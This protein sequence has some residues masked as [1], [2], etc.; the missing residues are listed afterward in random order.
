MRYEKIVFDILKNEKK[1]S[2]WRVQRDYAINVNA[3]YN[4]EIITKAM[5]KAME[6]KAKI[7]K[8][9]EKYNLDNELEIIDLD[10]IEKKIN[11]YERIND[12]KAN[13]YKQLREEILK[14]LYE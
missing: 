5:N 9:L 3:V 13:I 4:A 6:L 1:L 11:E 14:E 8:I 12:K 2:D 10:Y 7:P